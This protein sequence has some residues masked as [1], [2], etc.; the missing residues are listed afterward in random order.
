M[1]YLNL[2]SNIGIVRK[3]GKGEFQFTNENGE[4]IGRSVTV[5][6][7][8]DYLSFNTSFDLKYG[9]K[10]K[11]FPFLGVGPR[12]DYLLS[13]SEQFDG[14]VEL[15]ELN[16]ISAGLIFK[17]GLKY[18]F[19]SFQIGLCADYYLDLTQVADWSIESTG[20]SGEVS[21]STFAI[22]LLI[23]YRLK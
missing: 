3:G 20:V 12:L 15:G 2:S 18:G 13:S 22:N 14:L 4:L 23:G 19:S 16:D 1:K 10:E 7:T 6:P 8:L 5:R 17:G 9:V 11:F 21:V